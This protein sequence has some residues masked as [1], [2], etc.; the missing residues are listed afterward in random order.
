MLAEDQKVAKA[1]E[2]EQSKEVVEKVVIE[3][4]LRMALDS[5]AKTRRKKSEQL[6]V[7]SSFQLKDQTL[8]MHLMN[9][10]LMDLFDEIR[11]ELLDFLRKETGGTRIEVGAKIVA[12][13][14]KAKPRTEQEKFHAMLEK[15]PA[16]K[17][18]KDDL[19]MDLVY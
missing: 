18:L 7:K 5:F 19:G 2:V 14:K 9:Q 13:Q 12:D 8:E 6:I 17:D 10:T 11:Q 4:E 3:H 15:N 1:A 16:L